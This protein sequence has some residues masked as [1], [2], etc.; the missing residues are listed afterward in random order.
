MVVSMSVFLFPLLPPHFSS[1]I[2][3]CSERRLVVVDG[4]VS[5]QRTLRARRAETHSHLH[6]PDSS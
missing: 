1:L 6:Q 4:L 2:P 3:S 5:L